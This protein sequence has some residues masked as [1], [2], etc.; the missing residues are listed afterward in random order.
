MF[1]H[2][3]LPIRIIRHW[4]G[5]LLHEQYP[6][7]YLCLGHASP[8]NADI[9]GVQVLAGFRWRRHA[10]RLPLPDNVPLYC[11]FN[12]QVYKCVYLK[13]CI[14]ILIQ[15]G[16]LF[17]TILHSS[18]KSEEIRKESDDGKPC[19]SEEPST[20]IMKICSL[21]KCNQNVKI[22]KFKLSTF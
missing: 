20:Y 17:N 10:L 14:D 8:K 9:F 11:H 2:H 16:T 3:I 22:I 12:V 6:N 18:G 21:S 13:Q 19:Q 4:P 7:S 1:Q 15:S 5:R